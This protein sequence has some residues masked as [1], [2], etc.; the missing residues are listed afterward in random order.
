MASNGSP[1]FSDGPLPPQASNSRFAAALAAYAVLGLAAG[2]TLDGMIRWAVWIFLAGLAV[3]TWA[4]WRA[5][6]LS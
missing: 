3:K 1:D 5:A 6:R 2:L 4:A